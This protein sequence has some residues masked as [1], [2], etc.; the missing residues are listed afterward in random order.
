MLVGENGSLATRNRQLLYVPKADGGAVT[1]T[2]DSIVRYGPGF[3]LAAF[4]AF[5]KKTGLLQYAGGIAPRNAFTAPPITTIDLRI[6]QEIPGFFPDGAKAE[7]YLDIE[8]FGNLLNRKWGVIQQIPNP[9]V[10]AN[11]V[12]RNCQFSGVCPT[13]GDYYQYDSFVGRAAT[14]FNNQSV[15]QMKIGARFKF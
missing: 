7:I 9:Y 2:S 15:W 3:D 4:N 6:S 1:A 10:S 5:L 11:V 12:A 14:S 13:V 8:N